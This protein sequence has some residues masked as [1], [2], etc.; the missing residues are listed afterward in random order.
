MSV[1]LHHLAKCSRCTVTDFV[2]AE[3][4]RLSYENRK[5][6]LKK[7]KK[8]KKCTRSAASKT[9]EKA[10]N[11][12]KSTIT[13]NRLCVNTPGFTPFLYENYEETVETVTRLADQIQD[14]LQK[15][16]ARLSYIRPKKD[17]R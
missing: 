17:L 13:E 1:P 9:Y 12:T 7:K 11:G 15:K 4:E 6:W 16:T 5:K 8:W 14:I 3:A 2:P 10:G